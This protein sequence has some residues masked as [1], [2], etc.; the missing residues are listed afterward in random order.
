MKAFLAEFWQDNTLIYMVLSNVKKGID[1]TYQKVDVK[2]VLLKGGLK[3]HLSFYD[4][5]QVAHENVTQDE[6]N[7]Y[8]ESHLGTY[9]RQAMIYST[10]GDYQLLFSK[11]GK[12]KVIKKP[13]SRQLDQAQLSHNRSKQYLIPEGQPCDFMTYLGVMD[14]SG[15]VFKKKYDKFRQLNKYLEFVDDALSHLD[16]NETI[17]IIDFGCGKAYLTFALYYY[18][19]KDKG[20]KVDI[21]GLDLKKEVIAYCNDV[22]DA[23]GY[24]GLRF[25]EGDIKD[26]EYDSKVDMVVSLHACDTATDEALAKAVSWGASVIM[27]VPCC[28]HELFKQ[29]Q[30]QEMN[31]LIKHGVVRDKLVT[32]LTDSLR[33][34]AL[35]VMG[36]EVQV[37]EFIDLEHT[38]KNILIRAYAQPQKSDEPSAAVSEYISLEKTFSVS[39]HIRRVLGQPFEAKLKGSSQMNQ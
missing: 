10:K 35:E 18:L 20:Y 34:S 36:Y 4:E 28:Q 1:K 24:D 14:E 7:V 8:L 25:E 37:L 3:Y 30:N 9:F 32:L 27:A 6:L 2:P 29:V 26:Y 38:P 19:V 12:H 15:R 39:P 16:H 17:K 22:K 33:A 13:A 11:K 23:L 5:K 31:A 21:V